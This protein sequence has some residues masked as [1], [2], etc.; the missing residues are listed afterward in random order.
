M[1]EN[2]TQRMEN[3][4]EMYENIYYKCRK[5]TTTTCTHTSSEVKYI[6]HIINRKDLSMHFNALALS[7]NLTIT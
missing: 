7:D 3:I 1:M 5:M 4:T 6:L 2:V